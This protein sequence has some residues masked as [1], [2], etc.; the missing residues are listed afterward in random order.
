M[1]KTLSTLVLCLSL[2]AFAQIPVATQTLLDGVKSPASKNVIK[3]VLR[4]ECPKD[5]AKGTGFVV[6]GVG[7]IATNAHVAGNCSA[8]DLVGVSPVSNEPVKFSSM[9]KDDNR[10]I[11]LLCP[12]KA[13]AFSL[14][15]SGDE[16][17]LVETEVETWGYPLRYNRAAPVLS[18]GY[19]AGYDEGLDDQGRLKSPLVEH[20][21]VNGAFNPGNSGGP[22]IDRATGNVV[23]IVVE[24]W[25]LFLPFVE[26]VITALQ[27]SPTKTGSSM[28]YTD[29]NGNTRPASNEEITAAALKEVYNKSQVMVGEAISVSELNTFIKEKKKDLACGSK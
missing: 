18:R 13:L 6:S 15:L 11:A 28:A 4:I 3:S 16:Q 23:G 2:H 12:T 29:A 7:V 1:R 5:N 9:V 10:D 25:G 22:L 27:N 20:L 21:I 17:P 26:Q 19:L 8:T 24:K 14:K